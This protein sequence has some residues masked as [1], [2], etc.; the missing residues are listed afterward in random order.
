M[1]RSITG[2]EMGEVQPLRNAGAKDIAATAIMF[3]DLP[4]AALKHMGSVPAIGQ[5]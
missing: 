2:S 5:A 4:I 1:A 3:L